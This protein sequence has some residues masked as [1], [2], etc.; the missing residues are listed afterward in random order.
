MI[1]CS[2]LDGK[3]LKTVDFR[4]KQALAENKFTKT[5]VNI[6]QG[7]CIVTK[8]NKRNITIANND[9]IDFASCNYLGLDLHPEVM[10]AI[11]PMVK[12]WGTHPS[13]TRMV[14][15][16]QPY[17]D[18]EKL[19]AKFIGAPTCLLFPTIAMLNLGLIPLIVGHTGLVLCDVAAHNT[20]QE[21]CELAQ[22]RGAKY[23]KF[24]YNNPASLEK[25]LKKYRDFHPKLIAV[26]GVY[27]MT[28]DYVD[29]PEYSRLAQEYDALLY[30]DDA[31]G[32]RR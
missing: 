12:Q 11:D 7:N 2:C 10:A 8:Q 15:S 5:L 19:I 20:I 22:S 21:A 32:W 4:E 24:K 25:M 9:A 16:P 23:V 17:D 31:H 14:A 3:P 1:N 27:S 29:L 30:V 13:W 28:S 18:L 26:D 6:P